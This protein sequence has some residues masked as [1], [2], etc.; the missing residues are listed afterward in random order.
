MQAHVNVLESATVMVSRHARRL[1]RSRASGWRCHVEPLSTMSLIVR[2][3]STL[4]AAAVEPLSTGKAET[5]PPR[6]MKA[7]PCCTVTAGRALATAACLERAHRRHPSI[8]TYPWP[9]CSGRASIV[10]SGGGGGD[11][12][13]RELKRDCLELASELIAL[14][15][16][17]EGDA[18]GREGGAGGQQRKLNSKSDQR[19][20]RSTGIRRV[21]G[22]PC[23]L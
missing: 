17:L 23:D 11:G 18:D 15:L 5:T 14:K 16:K 8:G 2:L 9:G 3:P 4:R 20:W 10:G 7:Y 1:M 12:E 22:S 21:M 6:S 19:M 13:K